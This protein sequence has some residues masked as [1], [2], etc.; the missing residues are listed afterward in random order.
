MCQS[1]F[2]NKVA[3]RRPATLFKKDFGTISKKIFFTEHLRATASI[4]STPIP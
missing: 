2:F 4:Y 3:G 1:L